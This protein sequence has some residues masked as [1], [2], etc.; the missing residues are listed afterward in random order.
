MNASRT[1]AGRPVRTGDAV[2]R[3]TVDLVVATLDPSPHLESEEV[4]AEL[5]L[6]IPTLS[7]LASGGHF[8][9]HGVVL[10]AADLRLTI[11]VPVGERALAATENDSAPRGAATATEWTLHLPAPDGLATLVERTAAACPHISTDAA[12]ASSDTSVRSAAA[13]DLSRLANRSN[14]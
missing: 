3:A 11:A 4:R 12:P 8:E 10:A 9:R 7:L 2:A 13:V 1:I 6:A 5:E 14:R